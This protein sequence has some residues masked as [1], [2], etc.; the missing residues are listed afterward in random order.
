MSH[1]LTAQERLEEMRAEFM[2]E[3]TGLKEQDPVTRNR[4]II[5]MTALLDEYLD[6]WPDLLE[7]SRA[8]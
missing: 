8:K 5:H 4:V 7:E 2:D 6:M 1:E 3:T